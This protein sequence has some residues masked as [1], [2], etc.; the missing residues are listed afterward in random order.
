MIAAHKLGP[1]LLAWTLFTPNFVKADDPP[2]AAT[3]GEVLK[4]SLEG[5]S[6]FPGTVRDYWVYIPAQYDPAKPACV[7]VNQDGIQFNAPEVFD[8]LIAA[9]ERPVTIGVFVAPGR[10]PAP[11]PD[12]LDRLNRSFEYDTLSDAYVQFLLLELLPEVETKT[13]SDGRPLRL[14][15]KPEDRAIGGASSG[16]ICAFTAAWEGPD[17]FRRVFSAIGTYVGMH[18]GNV[19][20]TLVRKYE[21]KPI[22]IYLQ[23]G[24]NDQNSNRGDW[25][26]AN[27]ELE[28]ALTFAGYEVEHAW[29]TGGHDTKHSTE[30]FPEAMRW[31]WKGWPESPR[32]G[33]G[34]PQMQALLV[35]GPE[36]EQL[37]SAT[38]L[39]VDAEGGVLVARDSD[40]KL[41]RIDP[42]NGQAAEGRQIENDDRFARMAFGPDG[43][44][45]RALAHGPWQFQQFDAK[46]GPVNV[47]DLRL[48]LHDQFAL[49]DLLVDHEGRAYVC[50]RPRVPDDF[51]GI[52]LLEP[53]GALKRVAMVKGQPTSMALSPDH[54]LLYVTHAE[55]HWVWSYQVQ[56]DGSLANG[57]RFIHLQVPDAGTYIGSR[58]IAVDTD[59]RVYVGTALGIQ[60]CDPTGRVDAILPV[61]GGG[62][63]VKIA[64][65]GRN[66]DVLYVL[67]RFDLYRRPIQHRGIEAHDPPRKPSAP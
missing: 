31:L 53:G 6:I 42:E 59:G 60:V 15:Q 41:L 24:S 7:Y 54:S 37:M 8:R 13:A 65:G 49:T 14:S 46:T 11:G 48:D 56:P 18:G 35:E 40:A 4:F 30:I 43:R 21:P 58:G 10:V 12:A 33:K 17:A 51:G 62:P 28:R 22:R 2:T 34:S 23:D 9:G 26:M 50:T 61:P 39:A 5:S 55:D 29:G 47:Q 27:Q 1:L 3:R 66:R 19:Y 25:W 67:S 32:A 36:W 57:Q 45:F 52:W 16:A 63:I 64:L 20:P 44:V 38:D